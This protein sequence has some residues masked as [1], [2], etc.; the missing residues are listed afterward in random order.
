MDM[1]LMKKVDLTE[2]ANLEF[3]ADAFNVFN[4]ATFWSGDQNINSTT[5]GVISS[6]FYPRGS[7]NSGYT[8]D[9]EPGPV[10]S[11]I[12][13]DNVRIRS[14]VAKPGLYS[15]ITQLLHCAAQPLVR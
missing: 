8:C 4:H 14:S 1:S 9:S 6:M 11:L 13:S 7:C 5:F 12:P 10:Q 15:E 2:K 3:R